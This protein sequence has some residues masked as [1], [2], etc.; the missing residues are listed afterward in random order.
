MQPPQPGLCWRPRQKELS[1]LQKMVDLGDTRGQR[2]RASL[3]S[4]QVMLS[5]QI[6]IAQL[7]GEDILPMPRYAA[8]IREDWETITRNYKSQR[9]LLARLK[10]QITPDETE[11]GRRLANVKFRFVDEESVEIGARTSRSR[12]RCARLARPAGGPHLYLG[13]SAV[14]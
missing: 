9:L 2:H 5:E 7:T 10:L 8:T 3:D 4:K 13:H 11:D 1:K 6:Q 12:N 14:A